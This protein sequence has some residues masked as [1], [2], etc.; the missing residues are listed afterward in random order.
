MTC[1]ELCTDA[2]ASLDGYIA[3]SDDS[4]DWLTQYDGGEGADADPMDGYDDVLRR[5]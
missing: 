5:T 4:I 2:A 3:E 1:P